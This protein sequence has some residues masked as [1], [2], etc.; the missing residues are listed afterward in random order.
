MTEDNLPLNNGSSSTTQV[1]RASYF[2]ISI[3]SKEAGVCLRFLVFQVM[4]EKRIVLFP[5]EALDQY[6]YI[7]MLIVYCL[8][9]G[10]ETL[11]LASGKK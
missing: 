5:N 9:Q 10:V 6:I 4:E 1:R 2:H 3:S 11:R 8:L 7:R